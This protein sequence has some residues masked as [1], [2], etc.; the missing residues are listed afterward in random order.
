MRDRLLE[1]C[2]PV[3]PNGDLYA[4]EI[5]ARVLAVLADPDPESAWVMAEALLETE[6]W[7][8]PGRARAA[9]TALVAHLRGES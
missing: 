6:G 1:A 3:I 2:D 4:P 8:A 5:L 7:G 9:L